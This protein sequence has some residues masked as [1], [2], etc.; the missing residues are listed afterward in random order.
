MLAVYPEVLKECAAF[1]SIVWF[2]CMSMRDWGGILVDSLT[3]TVCTCQTILHLCAFVV[4]DI[5]TGTQPICARQ[6]MCNGCRVSMGPD[7]ALPVVCLPTLCQTFQIGIRQ[8][9]ATGSLSGCEIK[10]TF[11]I[12]VQEIKSSRRNAQMSAK[13]LFRWV[14]IPYQGSCEQLMNRRKVISCS[15]ILVA[16]PITTPAQEFTSHCRDKNHVFF[17]FL[18]RCT[19]E[20]FL[21]SFWVTS[22]SAL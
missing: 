4:W 15:I 12:D 21:F 18:P 1:Q 20:L 16:S 8:S 9:N 2:H 11:T 22:S 13:V 3:F 17:F 14:H 7:L 19:S 6:Q 10:L 5:R